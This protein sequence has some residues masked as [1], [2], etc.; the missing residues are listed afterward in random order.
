MMCQVK[1]VNT[2]APGWFWGFSAKITP[3]RTWLCGWDEYLRS[4][5]L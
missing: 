5:S 2:L 1:E 4:C 3:K